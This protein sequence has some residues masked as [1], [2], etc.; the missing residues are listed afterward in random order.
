MSR[1]RLRSES[2]RGTAWLV[3][4]LLA[5]LLQGSNGI[6]AAEVTPAEVTPGLKPDVISSSVAERRWYRCTLGGHP[7]GRMIE[8]V[9]P[10]EAGGTR[11]SID[12]ELRFRRGEA[13][14]STRIR[15]WIDLSAD[16]VMSEMGIRQELGGVPVL[17][18]SSMTRS[19]SGFT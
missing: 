16:Q 2:R 4:T 5:V 3:A 13:E 7:C 9:D 1:L 17:S 10:F 12:L 15:T 18:T 19:S 8:T 6:T 11:S 14:A